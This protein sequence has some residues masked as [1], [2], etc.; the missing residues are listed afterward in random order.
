MNFADALLAMAQG[1]RVRL[2]WWN[3]Y[4]YIRDNTIRIHCSDNRDFDIRE[5]DDIL[6]TV[7]YMTSDSWQFVPDRGVMQDLKQEMSEL[8]FN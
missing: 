1:E 7:S 8:R 4:W 3:G 2:P 6:R 5:S